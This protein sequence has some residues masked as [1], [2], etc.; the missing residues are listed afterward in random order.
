MKKE[1]A[2]FAALKRAKEENK[3]YRV[4]VRP[5]SDTG[6]ALVMTPHGG[7]IERHVSMIT[8]AI[9]DGDLDMYCF[10]GTLGEGNAELHI[11]SENFDED[12]ALEL[13]KTKGT[14]VA[15][16][17]RADEG[18]ADTIYLG[19]KDADLV[20]AIDEGLR[21]AGLKTKGSGHRFPGTKD[22]NIV[23]RG[24]TGKGA[25]L[26]LPLSLRKRLAKEPDLLETFRGAVRDAMLAL[27]TDRRV[28]KQS[29]EPSPP[30][31][32]K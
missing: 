32:G 22:S 20:A 15:I 10:E 16:H 2:N 11:T 12:R 18:D 23:N 13:L 25:Q 21:A 1:F 17:G 6:S 4:V 31:A 30:A 7:G 5:G 3:D 14:V 9:A 28:Q 27:D 19:G 26:E 29:D 24:L 8:A